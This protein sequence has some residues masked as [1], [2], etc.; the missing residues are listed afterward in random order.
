V[1]SGAS[2]NSAITT[3]DVVG[4]AS[5]AVA[6]YRLSARVTGGMDEEVF[7]L[8]TDLSFLSRHENGTGY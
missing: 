8:H 7:D 4:Y 1:A 3:S 2:F 6:V 5:I